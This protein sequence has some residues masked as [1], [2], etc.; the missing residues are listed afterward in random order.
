VLENVQ[1]GERN[2]FASLGELQTYLAQAS[3][4]KAKSVEEG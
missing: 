1:T 4:P 3:T 2:G